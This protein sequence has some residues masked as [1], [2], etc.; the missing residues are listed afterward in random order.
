MAVHVEFPFR[1]FSYISTFFAKEGL[2]N[3]LSNQ[4]S[5]PAEN[6]KGEI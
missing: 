3:I 4:N 1:V 6:K 5:I 2:F